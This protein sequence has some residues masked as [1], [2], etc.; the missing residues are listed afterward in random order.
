M[1][2]RKKPHIPEVATAEKDT[3]FLYGWTGRLENP[4]VVLRKESAGQGVKLYEELERDWQV[5]SMLQTRSLALQACEWQVEPASDKRSDVKVAEYVHQVLKEANFDGLTGDLMQGTLT[6]YKPSEIMWELSEGDIWVKELRGRRP[7]RFVFDMDYRLRLLTLSNMLDGEL[8]PE[9]KFVVY[10]F[11]GHDFNPYGR[12][13][14]YH[15]YWPVW[16]KKNGIKFWMVFAEKFGSPTPIGKYPPGTDPDDKKILLAGLKAIQQE[17]G[18]ILP[19]TMVVEL[20]EAKRAGE[21]SYEALCEYFDRSISKIVLGQTLTSQSGDSGS[22]AL[23]EVHNQ[24]RHEILKADA[25]SIS[26]CLN[27]SAVRWLV[28]YNFPGIRAYPKVWRRTEPE[29]DLKPLAERDKILLVDIGLKDRVADTYIEK[30]FNMPLA[31]PGERTIGQA[32]QPEPE[33]PREFSE[34]ARMLLGQMAVERTGGEA[35]ALASEEME[36][37]LEPIFRAMERARS[38]EEI[39]EV[40]EDLY[41]NL[42][43]SRFQELLQRALFHSSLMGYATAET[44]NG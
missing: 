23:G 13:L 3:D 34:P 19:E 10:T 32:L 31:K 35:A 42:E 7:S 12:G 2:E 33:P 22:Y 29:K 26:E 40:I 1:A 38:L 21:S 39:A 17:T 15:L 25:D 36:R 16:F 9:R 6:G 37:A 5:F 44:E 43:N 18:I 4:D 41:P 27:R 11:G 20:L 30:T 28:D 8:V 24:V 14:G